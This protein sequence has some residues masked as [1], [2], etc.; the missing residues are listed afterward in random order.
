VAVEVDDAAEVV[1]RREAAYLLAH[2]G[3]PVRERPVDPRQLQ[4]RG[5]GRVVHVDQP[6]GLC[7]RPVRPADA[8]LER[9]LRLRRGESLRLAPLREAP[10]GRL[11]RAE[12]RRGRPLAQVRGADAERGGDGAAPADDDE[13]TRSRAA[14][15]GRRDRPPGDGH[16]RPQRAPGHP[17][18]PP[19]LAAGNDR[20]PRPQ[21]EWRG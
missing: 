21:P 2:G 18:R 3:D 20:G 16:H 1:H 8:E 13:E 4:Q 15:V 19:Q 11:A 10:L 5:G 9:E 6:R 14:V 12:E 7:T 17:A